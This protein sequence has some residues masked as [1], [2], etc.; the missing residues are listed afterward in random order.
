MKVALINLIT[1]SR[2]VLA[3]I[4]FLLLAIDNFL[5]VA[6]IFLMDFWLEGIL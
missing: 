1:L 5:D 3:I 6:Q 4:I 2:I